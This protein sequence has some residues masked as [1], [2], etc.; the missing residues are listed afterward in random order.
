MNGWH[1]MMMIVVVLS[2][3]AGHTLCSAGSKPDT[4]ITRAKVI[5][6]NGFT[7]KNEKVNYKRRRNAPHGN[8]TEFRNI[9]IDT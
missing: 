6:K 5:Y 7:F 1:T 2:G 9:Q 8:D 3:G 4:V